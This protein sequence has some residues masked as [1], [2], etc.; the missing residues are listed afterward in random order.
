MDNVY[1]RRAKD[2]IQDQLSAMSYAVR[3]Q[4]SLLAVSGKLEVRYMASIVTSLTLGFS[5]IGCQNLLTEVPGRVPRAELNS[6]ISS[7]ADGKSKGN[8]KSMHRQ[9]RSAL[10]VPYRTVR[11]SACDP[12]AA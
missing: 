5:L 3:P 2:N 7:G 1:F 6:P 9:Y 10:T 8:A 12:V 4:T 11:T